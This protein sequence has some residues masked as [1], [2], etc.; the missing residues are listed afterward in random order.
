L[1]LIGV[2]PGW[3]QD[4][5]WNEEYR[6]KAAFVYQFPQFI[7]W[8]AAALSGDARLQICV[9]R[10]NPFGNAL[11]DLVAGEALNGHAIGIR[12]VSGTSD[13]D[14]CHVL[15]VA[16]GAGD[17]YRDALRRAADKPVLTVGESNTFLEQG[18]IIRLR[19]VDRRVRFEVNADAAKRAGL[20]LS[21]QLLDLA[22]G[23]RGT[24]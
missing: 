12:N 22:M 7:E 4:G 3:A 20:R 9:A 2:L 8:P 10:P 1:L 11:R 24:T 16:A 5:R 13:V 6:V 17:L 23:V 21:S 15:F 19:I 14:G 18:G